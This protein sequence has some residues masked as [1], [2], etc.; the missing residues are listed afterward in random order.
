MIDMFYC[1]QD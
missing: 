1:A